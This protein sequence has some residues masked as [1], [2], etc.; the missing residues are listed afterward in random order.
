M[1]TPRRGLLFHFTHINNLTSI[2]TLGLASDN[3]VQADGRLT[4]EV[5]QPGIKAPRRER[6]V[7]CGPG[8]V[9]AD[10]VPFYFAARSPML[11]SI[12]SGRVPTYQGGQ[13]DIVYLVSD[14][15]RM[16]ELGLPFVFTDRNA[17]KDYAAF[18]NDLDQIDHLIDWPLMEQRM[19]HNTTAEPD[20]MERRMAE[21]LVHHHVPWEALLG[22]VTYDEGRSEQAV[23]LLGNVDVATQV[24]VRRE[25][26]F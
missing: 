8:G 24:V 7:P 5:G 3:H 18:N 15:D 1:T 23:H 2:A 6:P 25:W 16:V 20:R 10:Y 13:A 11:G 9:V 22:V 21:F 14:I 26:Y 4:T 17:I 12:H 19:W